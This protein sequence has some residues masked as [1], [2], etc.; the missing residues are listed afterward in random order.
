MFF[1][2]RFMWIASWLMAAVHRRVLE[3]PELLAS[4]RQFVNGLFNS[5]LLD[6]RRN[7]CLE[8]LKIALL[9]FWCAQRGGFEGMA[10]VGH[11]VGVEKVTSV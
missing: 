7:A 1:R 5:L 8:K 6:Q 11:R 10:C 9:L 4:P 3:V 2:M